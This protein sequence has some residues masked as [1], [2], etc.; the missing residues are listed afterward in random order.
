MP[1]LNILRRK[2]ALMMASLLMVCLC[3]LVESKAS[4][5]ALRVRGT[6]SSE[7]KNTKSQIQRRTAG[8]Q[9]Y[10]AEI[11]VRPA[12]SD[13]KIEREED[14]QDHK[15]AAKVFGARIAVRPESRD[16]IEEEY[17]SLDGQAIS[18]SQES[19]ASGNDYAVAKQSTDNIKE[20]SHKI[21]SKGSQPTKKQSSVAKQKESFGPEQ[22]SLDSAK[23]TI[24]EETSSDSPTAPQNE[25]D[26]TERTDDD[27]EGDKNL[28]NEPQ[29]QHDK[30][31]SELQLEGSEETTTSARF[32]C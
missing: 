31:K 8:A 2:Q 28:R 29:P 23:G 4:V 15:G 12:S 14:Y 11:A 3:R 21:S 30:E 18:S 32:P 6:T 19:K 13:K 1:Q 26:E 16:P 27:N 5:R 9:I 17:V 24:T 10:G 22:E 7:Q 20:R 25:V